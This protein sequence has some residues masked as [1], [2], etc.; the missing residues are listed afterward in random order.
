MADTVEIPSSPVAP[1]KL[2]SVATAVWAAITHAPVTLGLV[3][4]LWIVGIVRGTIAHGPSEGVV[5]KWGVGL[6]AFRDGHWWSVVTSAMYCGG[7]ANYVNTTL[8]LLVVGVAVERRIGVWRMLGLMLVSQVGGALLAVGA[9]W[10]GARAEEDW[11][12]S[13]SNYNEMGASPAAAGLALAATF[14]LS[15]LWR[16]RVRL[17]LIAGLLTWALYVGHIIDLQRLCGGVVG[18]VAGLFV[19]GRAVK[20]RIGAP[21]HAE[22]RVLV[23]M[24]VAVGALGAMLTVV[25]DYAIGPLSTYRDLLVFPAWTEEEVRNTCANPEF[26]L[27][28][29]RA[30]AGDALRGLPGLLLGLAPALLLLVIAEG[31]RRGRRLAWWLGLVMN[32]FMIGLVAWAAYQYF[33]H[34]V[35][36][37]YPGSKPDAGWILFSYLE[38]VLLCVV[39]VVILLATRRH[40]EVRV[41]RT[42]LVGFALYVL[43]TLLVVGFGY[44]WIGQLLSDEFDPEA[45][46]ADLLLDLPVRLL[47]T[48]YADFFGVRLLPTGH[49]AKLL[50]GYTGLVFWVVILVGLLAL[51]LR[52]RTT[53]EP[54]AADRARALL[55]RGGSNLSY[56]TTWEGNDYWFAAT[57]DAAVAYRVI[58]GVAVTTGD[59]FGEP[60]ARRSA[61]AGFAEFCQ[62]NGWTPCFYSVTEDVRRAAEELGWSAVQVAEDTVLP[63]PELKFSGKKWQDVR[64]ALNN[65]GKAGITAQWWRFPEAPL[66]ISEQIREISEDWVADKG[67]PEMGFTL[68]SLTELDDPRVRCLVAVDAEGR[69]HGVTSWLPVYRDGEPVGWTLDFMRRGTTDF[70]G[71]MEFLIA[72]AALG[73]KEEGAEFLSLS[74][75]PLAR[76][77]RGD[78]PGALQKLLDF[79][80]RTLEPVYGFRSL[81]AFKAKFQP[82]YQPMFM[83]YPDPA[84]LPTIA[85]AI[86]RAYLPHLTPA[87]GLRLVR[88]V[89]G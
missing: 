28:C 50:F 9:I 13:I 52:S 69:V 16:R 20:G 30:L 33:R 78:E 6:Q 56:M 38:P 34:P 89:V 86:G 4:A 75:A 55:A 63:L 53:S 45:S 41:P 66:S 65:A 25:V 59:P 61:V 83:A 19:F 37:D 10:L 68:G 2:R 58:G 54:G 64:T 51:F 47:P 1:S 71:V 79:T 82:V 11:L 62:D 84:A 67:L 15:A 29:R 88:K 8:L 31:L 48:G 18:L 87:Q 60:A 22:T 5:E 21:S 39:T 77:D 40:F 80:G 3:A 57:D 74:G 44:L 70:R 27:D 49:L 73:F 85:S 46:A 42:N 43:G 12:F 23:A 32:L 7:V 72:S 24:V 35:P 14:G 36:D 76:L 81:F 17:L 26:A